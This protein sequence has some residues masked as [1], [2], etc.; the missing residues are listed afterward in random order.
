M[1]IIFSSFEQV[2][3]MLGLI[4]NMCFV[5]VLFSSLSYSMDSCFSCCLIF[6]FHDVRE[7]GKCNNVLN[8]TAYLICCNVVI[9]CDVSVHLDLLLFSNVFCRF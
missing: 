3:N 1:H 9:S 6:G 8:E 7:I 4:L 5:L 2:P